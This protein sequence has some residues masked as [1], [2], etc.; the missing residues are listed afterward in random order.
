MLWFQIAVSKWAQLD[1]QDL[2]LRVR[3]WSLGSR[4]IVVLGLCT[5]KHERKMVLVEE[6]ATRRRSHRGQLVL[7]LL[8][9]ALGCRFR[10]HNIIAR[11]RI[12][13]VKT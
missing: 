6:I 1:A 9:L 4:I 11:R 2:D 3:A 12:R 7:I 5:S 10:M 13:R 8:Q